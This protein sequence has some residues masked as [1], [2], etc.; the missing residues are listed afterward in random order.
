M[1]FL[2]QLL[3]GLFDRFKAKNPTVAAILLLFL[4]T[5]LYFADQG[6]LLGL[7]SLPTWAAS[8]LQAVAA[9]LLAV[10]GSR[11]Y[12]YLPKK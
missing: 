11:T 12:N 6:T 2:T 5:L 8:A 1:D 4:G 10:T 7:F 9:F 3:A